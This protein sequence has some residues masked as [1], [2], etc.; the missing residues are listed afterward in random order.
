MQLYQCAAPL[1][2]LTYLI[3]YVWVIIIQLQIIMAYNHSLYRDAKK[4]HEY[5]SVAKVD[6]LVSIVIF[7]L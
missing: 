3:M 1:S 2:Q 4:W 6:V 7:Q 5:P